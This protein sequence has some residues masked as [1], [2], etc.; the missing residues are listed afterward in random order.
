VIKIHSQRFLKSTE[1]SSIRFQ[2]CIQITEKIRRT[3]FR[4][5]V[6]KYADHTTSSEMNLAFY[7]GTP[8]VIYICL[9][10]ILFHL[11]M[12]TIEWKTLHGLNR[13]SDPGLS[14]REVLSNILIYIRRK[15]NLFEITIASSQILIFIPGLLIYFFMVYGQ[16][17]PMTGESFAVYTILI[18]IGTFAFRARIRSQI[19]YHIQYLHVSLSDL[20]ENAL[21]FAFSTIDNKKSQDNLIKWLVYFVVSFG[22]VGLI[23]ILKSVVG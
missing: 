17:K 3:C 8:S 14:T 2:C 9:G 4:I 7:W 18:L 12:T 10:G 22:F 11:I 15:S 20:N 21:E 19:K 13:I 6:F 23:V 16:V 5:Y 1:G